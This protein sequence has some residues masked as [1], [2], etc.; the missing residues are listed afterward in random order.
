MDLSALIEQLITDSASQLVEQFGIGVDTA[1][2]RLIVAGDNPERL[3]SDAA[4]VKRA[5]LS[6]RFRVVGSRDVVLRA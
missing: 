5:G 3:R 4:F 2:E 6:P 1:T